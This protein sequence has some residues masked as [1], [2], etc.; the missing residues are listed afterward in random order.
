MPPVNHALSHPDI[1][2]PWAEWSEDQ[3]LHVAVCYSNPFRWRTRRELANDCI[4]H[5]AGS[6]NVQL[7]I[8]ELAYGARPFEVTK[9]QE[10]RPESEETTYPDY[11]NPPRRRLHR[12]RGPIESVQ[13]R[14]NHE[15]FH[16]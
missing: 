4:R 3:T 7:Y 12:R 14:T 2:S 9:G 11:V 10:Y 8:G 5:L 15:L 16:K 6:P 1:H 13:F